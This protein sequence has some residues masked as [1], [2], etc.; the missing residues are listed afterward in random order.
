MLYLIQD[1][2]ERMWLVDDINL[3]EFT[4]LAECIGFHQD[5]LDELSLS[6]E[7]QESIG[8]EMAGDAM[9]QMNG[10]RADY[11]VSWCVCP[12]DVADA[13]MLVPVTP[14]EMQAIRNTTYPRV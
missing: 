2:S 12:D 8:D 3:T 10:D 13:L 9:W 1:L 4:S 14:A 7:E 6:R 5:V 11:P